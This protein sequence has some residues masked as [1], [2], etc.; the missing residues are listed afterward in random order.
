[1][2]KFTNLVAQIQFLGEPITEHETPKIGLAQIGLMAVRAATLFESN[3]LRDC[4]DE[5]YDILAALGYMI[6]EFQDLIPIFQKLEELYQTL[7]EA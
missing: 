6:E 1:M 5:I 2:E 3:H 4:R 7:K